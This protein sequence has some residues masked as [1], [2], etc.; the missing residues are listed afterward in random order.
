[1]I[2]LVAFDLDGTI[3]ETL[4]MCIQVFQKT[5]SPHIGR[6]LP[7]E[8]V[9]RNFGLNVEGMLKKVVGEHWR[10]ALDDYYVHYKAMHYMCASP[11]DGIKEFICELKARNI[12]VA[13][14]TGKGKRS[15]EMT[16][17]QFGM[18]NY[19]D[20][21]ETGSSEKNIKAEAFCDIQ[22][23]YDLQPDEL[24]YVGDAVSDINSCNEAG[25][26]CLSAAWAKSAD[27]N[28]LEKYNKEHVFLT[29]G[30]LKEYIVGLL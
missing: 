2:K 6:M 28:R 15:C 30:A 24:V 13:L 27:L 19:F 21:M 9:V 23:Q 11:F 1:M 10:V 4:A 3:G 7:E 8:E 5:V 17:N 18:E 29:V 25:I 14:V 16:L 22:K 20:C 12:L 26:R